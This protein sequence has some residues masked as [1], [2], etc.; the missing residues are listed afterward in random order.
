MIKRFW[1][2][3][4]R[5]RNLHRDLEAE[6]AFHREMAQAAGNPIPFGN[7]AVIAEQSRDLWR[8][9]AEVRG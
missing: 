5:R 9:T 2:K 3:L 6:L 8:F 7:T 1:L 4:F